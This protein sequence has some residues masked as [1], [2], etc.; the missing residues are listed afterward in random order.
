MILLFEILK[1]R[2]IL[3]RKFIDFKNLFKKSNKTKAEK[4]PD[5]LKFL[6]K[7]KYE[8]LGPLT[9]EQGSIG[10]IFLVL[11]ILWVTRDPNFVDG[12]GIL[13]KKLYL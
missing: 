3:K 7:Y 11:I 9:W 1:L 2:L 8:S 12:W 4:K 10:T 6:M 13:F 5:E